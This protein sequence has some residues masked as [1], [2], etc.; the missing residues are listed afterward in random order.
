M[1]GN[2]LDK[3]K[4][5][6]AKRVQTL[7]MK[8]K[9]AS[10]SV[11]KMTESGVVKTLAFTSNFGFSAADEYAAQKRQTDDDTEND[12]D[13]RGMTIFGFPVAGIVGAAGS[14][15]GLAGWAGGASPY[16]GAVGEGALHALIGR[17]GRS[18]GSKLAEKNAEKDAE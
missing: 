7:D 9:E 5:W 1:A 16:V 4:P 15:M 3:P 17:A 12:S 18:A 14:V 2:Y 8:A 6:L 13:T 10:E 11:A